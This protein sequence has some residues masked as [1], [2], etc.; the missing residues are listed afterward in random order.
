M[1]GLSSGSSLDSIDS[2]LVEVDGVGLDVQIRPIETLHQELPEN[3]R[4]SLQRMASSLHDCR[5]TAVLHRIL[6]EA[7]ANVIRQLAAKA[8][9]SLEQ[10]LAIGCPGHTVWHESD[11]R[12]PTTLSLGMAAAVAERTGVTTVSDFR[13]RDVAAGGHGYPLTALIDYLLFHKPGEARVLVHLGGFATLVFLPAAGDPRQTV[14]FQAAP[15]N[16]MLNSFIRCLTGGR[17]SFDCGGRHAVQGRCLEMLLE[18]WLNHSA[19]LRSPPKSLP[20]TAFAHDFAEH[21]VELAKQSGWNMHD[22]LCT[23]THFVA[24]ATVRAI[25]TFLPERPARVLLSGGGVLN[26]FLWHLIE[27]RLRPLPIERTDV[28]GIPAGGRK[29]I[30]YAGLAALTLDG[31][32]ANLAT[33]TGAH[34][35]RILGSITPGSSVNWA[36]CLNWMATQ[37]AP[38]ASSTEAA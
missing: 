28:L 1:I 19:L 15:C 6:G 26:G 2:A 16:V 11:A 23:A 5:Q 29:A 38:L 31:V 24:A 27:Q 10:V 36:R 20:R 18:R 21:A 17:E 34:G 3:V 32:P 8:R 13:S 25:E 4:L 37:T 7:A 9:V 22:V 33:A 35:S 30:G 14:G 12:I